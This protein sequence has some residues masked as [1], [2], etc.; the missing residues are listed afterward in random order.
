MWE[1]MPVCH[2]MYKEYRNDKIKFY[3]EIIGL[4]YED[5]ADLRIKGM[6]K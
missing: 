2:P 1:A 4:C 5:I 6:I 3:T